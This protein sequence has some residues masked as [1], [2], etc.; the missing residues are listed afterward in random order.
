MDHESIK[1][2]LKSVNAE[3]VPY[4]TFSGEVV[5]GKVTEVYDG[6][7][8]TVIFFFGGEKPLK[9]HM[10]MYGYDSPEM[11]PL[12]TTPDRDMHKEAACK[13]KKHLESL[14]LGEIVRLEFTHEEKYGRLMGKIYIL[15]DPEVCVN[16]E[17]IHIGYGKPYLGKTKNP[18]TK[19]ELAKILCH[20]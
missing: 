19:D 2:K 6:D 16:D 18:F 9:Y 14:I 15:S 7:T 1:N 17:M 3:S 20:E 5:L 11:K 10:R 13:V 4:F 12:L 8:V